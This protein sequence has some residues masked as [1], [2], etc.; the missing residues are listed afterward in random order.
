MNVF[1]VASM[2]LRW[3]LILM[4]KE[5]NLFPVFFPSK[6]EKNFFR[7]VQNRARQGPGAVPGV[8]SKAES[9]ILLSFIFLAAK[10]SNRSRLNYSRQI[11]YITT[12]IAVYG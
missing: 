8:T 1:L 9:A 2:N 5:T 3:I 12:C 10:K 7:L 6:H 11:N 4:S